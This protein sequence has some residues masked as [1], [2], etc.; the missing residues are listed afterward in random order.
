MDNT[1]FK[2]NDFDEFGVEDEGVD[3]PQWDAWY[4]E[5]GDNKTIPTKTEYGKMIEEPHLDID[6]IGSFDKYIGATFKTNNKNNRGGNIATV[7][8]RVID[9][10]GSTIG[11]AH[12]NTLLGYRKYELELEDGTKA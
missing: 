6:N 9:V 5:Y 7:K 8:R 2:S 1:N 10:D 12:N 3:M 4:P 11:L